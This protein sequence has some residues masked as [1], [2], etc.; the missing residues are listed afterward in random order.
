MQVTVDSQ[1]A[2]EARTAM[3]V[4][5]MSKLEK[6]SWR[7]APRVAALDRALGGRIAAVIASR[8]FQGG[9]SESLTLYPAGAIPAE[10]VQLLGIGD[11]AKLDAEVVRGLAGRAVDAARS[12]R[13]DPLAICVP[14]LASLRAEAVVRALTEGALLAGYQ[15]DTYREREKDAAPF[16]KRVSLLIERAADLKRARDASRSAST[17]AECQNLTRQLSNEPANALP[18]AA[19]AASARRI[20]REVG[21]TVTVLEVAELKRQRMGGILAVGGGSAHTP[22][23]IV[24]DH[25]PRARRRA[26][27]A[28]GRGAR[29]P[30]LPTVCLV[31][32]GI[33]FDS[34]G[35]SIKPSAAMD[36]MKH[37]MSGAAAV[38]GA[39]R[40][41]ALLKLPIRVIGVI[42]AAENMPS[43]TAY[44]PG[45]VVTAMSGKT[46]EILNTDAEGR[47]VLADALHYARTKFEPDAIVDLA[48]LT[49]AC[50]VALGK[51][52][53]GLFGNHAGLIEAVRAAGEAS[54]E[55]AWPM[56]LWEEHRKAVRSDVADI[57]NSTGR[58][59]GSSTAAAFLANFVGDTPWAHL[60]IAGTAW[61]SKP[62]AYLK[63][64]ATGVGV[65]L[66]IELLRDW[67]RI[68]WKRIV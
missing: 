40:A 2:V 16:A 65:R 45:D 53:S 13:A 59:A 27:R 47:V 31:G 50:V 62:S 4:I 10:R 22:R 7:P 1:R 21:L 19:L 49:G 58:D 64:G 63:K 67:K 56:P 14:H 20:A 48:T 36:E 66:L 37:D 51:W 12:R 18:P 24:L 28:K 52:A 44:R 30:R 46:I 68:D 26:S 43:S 42:A 15:F 5:P 9:A 57:K 54:S 38:I 25:D 33:T 8:D 55:R 41:C 34:G 6:A 61:D 23:L 39:L 35:I 32:K 11:E 3:L 60:D 29:A 17:V